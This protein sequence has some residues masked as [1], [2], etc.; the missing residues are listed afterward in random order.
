MLHPASERPEHRP[1]GTT[2]SSSSGLLNDAGYGL[3]A[4]LEPLIT[5]LSPYVWAMTYRSSFVGAE[6][7]HATTNGEGWTICGP[8]LPKSA[9]K[10]QLMKTSTIRM[11]VRSV[12]TMP[13]MRPAAASL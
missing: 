1:D 10:C 11:I 4:Y 8:P 5:S 6:A 2:F 13:T 9:S 7:P 12:S 3:T